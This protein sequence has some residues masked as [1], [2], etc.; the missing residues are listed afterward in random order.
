MVRCRECVEAMVAT[1]VT[2]FYELGAGEV[3][4]GLAR[5]INR[6][7]ETKS[8]GTPDDIAAIEL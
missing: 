5:R 2:T 1:G 3:L 6:Q 8:I 7:L 4:S